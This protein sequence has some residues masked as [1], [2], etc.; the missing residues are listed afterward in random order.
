MVRSV[1]TTNYIQIAS[2]SAVTF[3]RV[4]RQKLKNKSGGS[5]VLT[6]MIWLFVHYFLLP[7]SSAF[8]GKSAD[9]PGNKTI[10][11][12]PAHYTRRQ[13]PWP[14]LFE[15]Q[16]RSQGR[17]DPYRTP[18]NLSMHASTTAAWHQP[19]CVGYLILIGMVPNYILFGPQAQDQE[20]CMPFT[21][22]PPILAWLN[23]KAWQ[24]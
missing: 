13:F 5:S 4:L 1:D 19:K 14:H 9:I 23:P 18:R 24:Y 22:T 21:G 8:R 6:F 17:C 3:A 12:H 16:P 15:D 2:L 7:C 20:W 10:A 11:T